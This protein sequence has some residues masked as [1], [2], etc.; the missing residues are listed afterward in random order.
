VIQAAVGIAASLGLET[1]AEGVEQFAQTKVLH[2]LGCDL[3]Q[4]FLFARPVEASAV[5]SMFDHAT[6]RFRTTAVSNKPRTS[7]R[8]GQAVPGARPGG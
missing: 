6:N 7:I 8:R 5:D 1:V 3:G 2:D 4:G